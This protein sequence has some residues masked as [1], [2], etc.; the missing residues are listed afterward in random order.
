M[1]NTRAWGRFGQAIAVCGLWALASCGGGS[2]SGDDSDAG[3]VVDAA[4]ACDAA[5]FGA[6][7]VFDESQ[8]RTYELS[9]PDADWQELQANATAE[10]Y[11]SA[12]LTYDGQTIENI[13]MR[14]KG[15]F[16]SLYFCFQGGEQVCDKLNLKLKFNEYVPG[17]RLHGLKRINL[18][19]MEAEPS[20]MHDAIG[21]K[22]FRDQ[23]VYAPRMAY[24]RIIV[25][26][27]NLGLYAA[28]EAIDG[29]F[30]R[31]NFPDGGEGNLY[32]EVWPIY[33]QEA[34]YLS[35]LETNE[36]ENPSADKMVRFANALAAAGDEDF[37]ATLSAWTD[38]DKYVDYMAVA[39]LIDHWDGT[40]GFYCLGSPCTNHNYFWYEST[41]EDKIW[42]VPWDLDHTFEE[43]SPIRSVFGMPDWDDVD[44]DCNPI[45]IFA[46]ITGQAP[47]CD[48]ILNRTARLLWD[49]YS[50]ASQELLDGAFSQEAMNARID[51]LAALIEDEVEADTLSTQT[52]EEWRAA[53]EALK[54]TIAA[55]RQHVQDKL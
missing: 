2:G 48:P 19:A 49:E 7:Y 27:E 5:A 13:G 40:V 52:V 44:A 47:G 12:T 6:D 9:L 33:D 28:I 53:V 45:P 8:I 37:V 51:A 35:A 15:S 41:S 17:Q 31:A 3:T 20:K 55:K 42:L 26:G 24:A 10:Q 22:L 34:P 43:P 29:R 18:H 14:F 4:P 46:G 21:Y 39:R 16:G 50:E 38:L 32:K 36:D 1:T 11:V 23:G 30:T 25:N 54:A